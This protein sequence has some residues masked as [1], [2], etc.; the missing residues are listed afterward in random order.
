MIK[1]ALKCAAVLMLLSIPVALEAADIPALVHGLAPL[2]KEMG[3]AD[4]NLLTA[5]SALTSQ[6]PGLEAALAVA[7]KEEAD[8]RTAHDGKHEQGTAEFD[9]WNNLYIAAVNEKNR[10][11]AQIKD[12]DQAYAD[13]QEEKTAIALRRQ[14]LAREIISALIEARHPCAT[15]LTQDSTDEALALCAA[16]DFDGADPNLPPLDPSIRP[17]NAAVPNSSIVVDEG[18]PEEQARK[19]E[20]VNALV[21]ASS[22]TQTGAVTVVPPAPGQPAPEPSLTDRLKEFLRKLGKK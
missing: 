21:R 2:T 14:E 22:A 19:R 17:P 20:R 13:A 9:T 16:V 6:K 8:I 18:T 15:T 11:A 7:A 5:G 4:A 3:A 1:T 10:I 12:M